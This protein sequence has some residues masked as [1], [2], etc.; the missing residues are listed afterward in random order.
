MAYNLVVMP[1]AQADIQEAFAY[2]SQHSP[3]AARRW[4]LTVREA[5]ETLSEMPARCALA[6]EAAKLGVSLR[7][8]LH[9]KHPSL[10]R[11]VFRIVEDAGEVHVL[12]VRHGARRPLTEDEMAP[13]L[14]LP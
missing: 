14:E 4:Y 1:Q 13:F 6:P 9:G 12:T 10:Y 11:I 7:Q 5:I 2:L 3:E 8:L